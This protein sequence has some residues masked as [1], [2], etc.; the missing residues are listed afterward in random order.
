MKEI[1][2]IRSSMPDFEEYIEEIRPIWE[3]RWL[4][5]YGVKHRELEARLQEYL[6]VPYCSLTVN[7]HY[8][9]EAIIEAYGLHGE[10]ITTPFTFISTT[11][12]IIRRGCTPV[13]CDIKADD[14]T[15]DPAKV[16]ELITDNTC[17]IMPV[18]VYGN[19]CDNDALQKIADKYGIK[20]IYDA[21]HAFGVE[22]NGTGASCLGDASMLS[23]HATK[24]FHTIEGG[25]VVTK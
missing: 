18:H 14:F 16:E 5:N 24:V 17:A 25:A 2:V 4:T 3:S 20:L 10:I 11:T 22:I 13:F 9:L 23:F 6:K 8:G 7:G 21:A 15:I 19:L 1:P 12:A